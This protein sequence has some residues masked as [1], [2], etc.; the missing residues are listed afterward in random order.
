VPSGSGRVGTS[1]GLGSLSVNQT[2]TFN[3]HFLLHL[4]LPL[5]CTPPYFVYSFACY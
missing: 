1:A 5:F 4:V 2:Y 3:R